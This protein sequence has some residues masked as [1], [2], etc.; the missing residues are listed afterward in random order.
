MPRK[1]GEIAFTSEVKAAQEQRGT[2]QTYEKYIANGADNDTI[3]P[4]IEEFI[5]QL[6][7][8]YL[9]TVGSNGY[10]YIQF[11]GGAPGFLKVLDEKTLGFADFLGNVQYITIGN[12]SGS[13]KAFLF[14]MDYRHRKRIKIWGRAEFVEG[15]EKLI[16]RLRVPGYSAEVERAILFHVEATSE[17]CPQHIPIR[18]SETE[19]EAI[20]APLRDRIAEL[21]QQLSQQN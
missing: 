10:P 15:D 9:G 12:L 19:V 4:K 16:A 11:R 17:N 7:G 20:V 5:A 3:T 13:D 21:E 8:F 18:Y 6:N 2:R 1:F 14:L